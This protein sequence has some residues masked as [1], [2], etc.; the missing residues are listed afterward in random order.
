MAQKIPIE[1]K[2]RAVAFRILQAHEDGNR[3]DR[4]LAENL[5]SLQPRGR[6]LANELV[7]GVVRQRA[8]LDHHLLF[9]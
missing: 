8:R 6:S 1:I 4:A 2:E 5:P 3:L 7:N 9:F